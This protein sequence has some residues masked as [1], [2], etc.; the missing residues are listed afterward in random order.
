MLVESGPYFPFSNLLGIHSGTASDL[1]PSRLFQSYSTVRAI[2]EAKKV[3]FCDLK[4]ID[5]PLGLVTV[6]YGIPTP[7][8]ADV[9]AF[10][11]YFQAVVNYINYFVFVF[12]LQ[13]AIRSFLPVY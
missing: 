7:L 1:C 11:T 4:A 6:D 3:A 10:C 8:P 9:G 5:D 2:Q 13:H 12:L